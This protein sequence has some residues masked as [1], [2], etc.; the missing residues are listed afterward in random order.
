MIPVEQEIV[1]VQ[2]LPAELGLHVAGKESTQSVLPFETPGKGPLQTGAQRRL[3][4]HHAR[5]DGQG[6]ALARKAPLLLAQAGFGAHGIDQVGRVLAV[7]QGETRIQP[8][9]LGVLAQQAV[10]H[11]VEGPGPGQGSFEIALPRRQ[12]R[13]PTGHLDRSSAGEGEQEDAPRIHPASHERRHPMRQGLGLARPGPSN[14]QQRPIAMGT[15]RS[16]RF[17]EGSFAAS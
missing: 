5:I 11:G 8:H 13:R 4:V 15:G 6:G 17:I 12:S 14:D 10:G 16:L 7:E 1:V 3:G 2:N 9:H